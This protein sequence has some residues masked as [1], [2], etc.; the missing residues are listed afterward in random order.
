MGYGFLHTVLDSL[1]PTQVDMEELFEEERSVMNV[2]KL[3]LVWHSAQT[4]ALA[5]TIPWVLGS[6]ESKQ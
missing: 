1:D 3:I 5:A 6:A 4:E 2:D